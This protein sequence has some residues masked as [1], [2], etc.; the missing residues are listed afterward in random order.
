MSVVP[1]M[2]RRGAVR[3]YVGGALWVLPT[4]AVVVSLVAGAVLAQFEVD[5]E[6][7]FG[8]SVVPRRRQR[9]A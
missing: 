8:R 5:S 1:S 3:E 6:T 9:G 4:I 7:G 2:S